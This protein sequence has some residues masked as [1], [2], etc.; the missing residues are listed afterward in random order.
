[1]RFY[2]KPHRYYCGID[3]HARRMY[4]CVLDA[5]G[6]IRVHR[7]GPATP[8]HFLTTVAAYREDLVVAVE[9]IF[10]WYWLADLCAREGIAFV[11]GH[12]LYMKAIHG[13]KAKNDKIDAHKIAALLRGGMMPQAYVYPQAMRATRDLMRRR[14][15]LMRQRAEL[16]AH[17]TNTN[18]Q[19]NLPAFGVRPARPA[20]R[21]GLAEHFAEVPVRKSIEVDLSVVEHYD[22]Q[23][24]PLE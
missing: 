5:E 16:L 7:N 2:T 17:I 20:E 4:I 23:L 13:G 14:N 8:E 18:H 6:Q 22:R 1:M 9:C 10:T 3:L 19:Y 12:A 11:L 15:Y 21:S 24:L